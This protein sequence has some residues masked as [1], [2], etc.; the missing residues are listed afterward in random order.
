MPVKVFVFLLD[1]IDIILDNFCL[2]WN[3]DIHWLPEIVATT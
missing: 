2:I 1:V 3:L